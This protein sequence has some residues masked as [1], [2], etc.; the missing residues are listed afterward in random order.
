MYGVMCGKHC[1]EFSSF[2]DPYNLLG[3]LGTIFKEV[4]NLLID[5]FF[6]SHQSWKISELS[7]ALFADLVTLLCELVSL[8]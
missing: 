3:M 4:K 7:Y 5:K 2:V 8:S 1:M 6:V